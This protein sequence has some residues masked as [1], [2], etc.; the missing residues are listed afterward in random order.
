MQVVSS[1]TTIEMKRSA[2]SVQL[3]L[4]NSAWLL[5]LEGVFGGGDAHEQRVVLGVLPA[6]AHEVRRGLGHLQE[7]STRALNTPRRAR[8]RGGTL[9]LSGPWKHRRTFILSML[10]SN[11]SCCTVLRACAMLPE[12]CIFEDMAAFGQPRSNLCV[13]KDNMHSLYVSQWVEETDKG[14]A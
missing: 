9:S 2:S 10:A 3:P 6:V 5:V 14:P 1:M 11:L 7:K 8:S 13:E 12:L 4:Q